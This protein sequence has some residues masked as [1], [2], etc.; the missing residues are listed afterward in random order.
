MRAD[1]E[2]IG[3]AAIFEALD[4]ADRSA[5]ALC[6]QGKKYAPGQVVFREGDPGATLLL[7]GEGSFVASVRA[8]GM[9]REVG[10]FG[11][12]GVIGA[13]ALVDRGPRRHTLT[14]VGPAVAYEIDGDAIALLRPTAP[15]AARALSTASLHALIQRLRKLEARVEAELDRSGL[16]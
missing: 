4:P 8:G 3:R 14:A 6:F 11:P 12:G 7:V 13:S 9:S 10:R 1:A 5:L 2:T 15:H 16:T